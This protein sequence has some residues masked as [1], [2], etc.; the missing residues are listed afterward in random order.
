MKKV[1]LGSS[2]ATCSI[3]SAFNVWSLCP[4]NMNRRMTKVLDR[5]CSG[6]SSS[7]CLRFLHFPSHNI[8]CFS[9]LILFVLFNN[10]ATVA[11]AILR[12]FPTGKDRK[13]F[14]PLAENLFAHFPPPEQI[15]FIKIQISTWLLLFQIFIPPAKGI[16][17]PPLNKTFQ[18]ITQ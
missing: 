12:V 11:W 8:S 15:P 14:L 18:V 16:N 3:L 2:R 9:N 7:N 4:G 13:G 5:S 6:I 10:D 17:S 1:H